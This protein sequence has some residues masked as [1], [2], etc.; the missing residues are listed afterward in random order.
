MSYA[1]GRHMSPTRGQQ[2]EGEDL[3]FSFERGLDDSTVPYHLQGNQSFDR[4]LPSSQRR[5]LRTDPR[6]L[7]QLQRFWSVFGVGDDGTIGREEYLEFHVRVAAVLIPSLSDEEAASSGIEDWKEDAKGGDTM[8]APLFYDSLFELADVYTTGIDG[9]A[10]AVWLDRLFRRITSRRVVK[11]GDDGHGEVVVLQPAPPSRARQR[12]FAAFRQTVTGQQTQWLELPAKPGQLGKGDKGGGVSAAMTGVGG[13]T[14]LATVEKEEEESEGEE[15]ESEESED[16]EEAGSDCGGGEAG[17]DEALGAADVQT[18]F[19]WADDA[20]IFPL[21]LY[22]KGPIDWEALKKGDDENDGDEWGLLPEMSTS[23]RLTGGK[24]E[25]ASLKRAGL[26]SPV[27]EGIISPTASLRSSWRGGAIPL[28]AAAI[29][30]DSAAVAMVTATHK[31]AAAAAEAVLELAGQAAAGVEDS[32]PNSFGGGAG[33]AG[34]QGD[35]GGAGGAAAA[36]TAAGHEAIDAADAAGAGHEALA[37]V[38]RTAGEAAIEAGSAARRGSLELPAA[39]AAAGRAAAAARRLDGIRV[40]DEGEAANKGEAADKRETAGEGGMASG[41]PAGGA[42]APDAWRH[43]A[44]EAKEASAKASAAAAQAVAAGGE[45]KAAAPGGGVAAASPAVVEAVRE[46]TAAAIAAAAAAADADAAAA[47]AAAGAPPGG[48][49]GAADAA[50]RAAAEAGRAADSAAEWAKRV[51]QLL[52]WS[53]AVADVAAAG[54]Q[55]E[56]VEQ[57]A[58]VVLSKLST[59]C[60]SSGGHGAVMLLSDVEPG[61]LAVAAA[62]S[63]TRSAVGL[64]SAPE[65]QQEAT[66]ISSQ[67]V[68]A[69]PLLSAALASLRRGEES[70]GKVPRRALTSAPAPGLSEDDSAALWLLWSGSGAPFGVVATDAPPEF[71]QPMADAAAAALERTWKR[72]QLSSFV[73]VMGSWVAILASGTGPSLPSAFLTQPFHPPT[74]LRVRNEVYRLPLSDALGDI[75]V[76]LHAKGNAL[77]PPLAPQGLLNEHLKQGLE[78]TAG[79]LP[80]LVAELELMVIGQPVIFDDSFGV[81]GQGYDRTSGADAAASRRRPSAAAAARPPSATARRTPAATPAAARPASGRARPLTTVAKVWRPPRR[82]RRIGASAAVRLLLPRRLQQRVGNQLNA[83]DLKTA[84]AELKTYREPPDAVQRTVAGVLCL[85]GRRRA[86]LA[87][88]AHI[89]PHLRAELQREMLEFDP[90]SQRNETAWRE[91]SAATEGLTSDEITRKGSLA[92]QTMLMWLEVNRLTRADGVA[93]ALA[94]LLPEGELS[95]RTAM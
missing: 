35:G 31:A 82:G 49:G 22:E 95:E 39:A 23:F 8:A 45:A 92:V 59:E 72:A 33:E 46:A 40:M 3:R 24:G 29:D 34:A 41:V 50:V 57:V 88:W 12:E 85:L 9:G 2:L 76:E 66:P 7:A 64:H 11:K 73:E 93:S 44:A 32:A 71:A 74:P 90:A 68:S 17:E 81:F 5:A 1:F 47:A 86:E 55:G 18:T 48:G 84:L 37:S 42:V 27:R 19:E 36:A 67:A 14:G 58:A 80:Q 53:A 89:R 87:S 10:Y 78:V 51:T 38:A 91:S 54:E 20:H 43:A 83:F 6:V 60:G 61:S 62:H 16:D 30:G 63:H 94:K 65:D 56:S 13:V 4:T 75:A 28:T 25:S 79:L 70:K 77:S 26:Q 21:V 52:R 15:E 69:S